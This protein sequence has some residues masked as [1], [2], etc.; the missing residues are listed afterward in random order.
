MPVRQ[1]QHVDAGQVDGQPLG[2]GEP[3]VAV[4]ADVEQHRRRAVALSGRGERREA[5]AGDAE[6]VE[7]DDAVV[8]VVLAARRDAPEEVGHLGKLRHARG[9]A[10]ERVG[11]VVDDDRD[12]ELVE[13]GCRGFRSG[14]HRRI[15]PEP[16]PTGSPSTSGSVS[17]VVWL[18][19]MSALGCVRCGRRC[20]VEPESLVEATQRRG[21]PP[22]ALAE[23]LHGGG[24]EERPD[25]GGV[26]EDGDGEP[27][28]ELLDGEDLAGG[29]AGED[30]DDEERGGGDDAAAALQADGDGEVAVAGL[31]VHLLDAREQEDLVVHREPEGEDEDEHRHPQVE[32]ADRVEAEQP[33]EVSFLE[34]PHQGTEAGAEAEDVH[35]DGLDRHDDRAG[36]EEQQHER[37]GDDHEGGEREPF[38]EPGLDVDELGGDAAD[39]GVERRRCAS[40]L[41]DERGCFAALGGAGGRDVDDGDAVGGVGP[42]RGADD[43]GHARD[44]LEPGDELGAVGVG[45]GDDGDGVGAACREPVGEG[46]C[47]RRAPRTSGAACGRRRSRSW[48]PRNGTPSRTSTTTAAAPTATAWP[49]TH[50]VSR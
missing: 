22:V 46:E 13:L 49:C 41:G 27:D 20:F 11:R 15:V 29:E 7:A 36:H 25:D 28:A 21:R 24:H 39:L 33:G 32:G 6:V 45:V 50:R 3:D 1:E 12:G 26:D 14:C 48:A 16:A 35:D 43:A 2:V 19:S 8:P 23:Q 31:V 44:L 30:D 9:D 42:D 18:R 40:Q 37:G 5:V 47:D 38:A 34:D 10:R 4:G 17:S